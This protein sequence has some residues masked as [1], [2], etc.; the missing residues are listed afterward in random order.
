V[1]VPYCPPHGESRSEKRAIR[2]SKGRCL[3]GKWDRTCGTKQG[4]R[5]LCGGEKAP[6]P[7]RNGSSPYHAE[8]SRGNRG[9]VQFSLSTY[10]ASGGACDV[11]RKGVLLPVWNF[12]SRFRRSRCGGFQRISGIEGLEVLG[13]VI[14]ACDITLPLERV[15]VTRPWKRGVYLN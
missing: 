10:K 7:Q 14:L 5:G 2:G 15:K 9:V 3:M 6:W 11:S 12:K 13:R 4:N 8:I 1:V